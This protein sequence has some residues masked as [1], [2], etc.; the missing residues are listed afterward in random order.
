MLKVLAHRLSHLFNICRMI[1]KHSDLLS[2]LETIEKLGLAIGDNCQIQFP[3]YNLL[4]FT[5]AIPSI[6]ANQPA[7][8]LPPVPRPPETIDRQIE[9]IPQHQERYSELSEH[10]AE[11][12]G[13]AFNDQQRQDAL[14]DFQMAVELLRLH[15]LTPIVQADIQGL[16]A[17]V[18]GQMA[19]INLICLNQ[20]D[21]RKYNV[22]VL[23]HLAHPHSAE[24][25]HLRER[26]VHCQ[27]ILRYH[28][29]PLDSG[30][31]QK[32]NQ[33]ERRLDAT[34]WREMLKEGWVGV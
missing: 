28:L 6:L 10:F 17:L 20:P 26:R 16:R 30:A 33:P 34:G 25:L 32:Q 15:I 24:E 7:L 27:R 2:C 8:S 14:K 12:Y 22:D 23:V 31:W 9:L 5:E 21:G 18:Y 11:Q 29:P 13:N 1:I 4:V 3:S 19:G